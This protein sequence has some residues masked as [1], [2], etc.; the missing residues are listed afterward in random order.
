MQ[1]QQCSLDSLTP[2]AN[3]PRQ[4]AGAVDKVAASIEAF[5][6]KQPIVV[7]K[8]N[9]II[10]GHTRYLAA[11]QLG[12]NTVPVLVADD[13]SPDEAK[14]YRLADNRTHEESTWDKDLLALELGDLSHLEFDLSLTGF[15]ADELA[16]LTALA[17]SVAQGLTDVDDCH[18]LPEA[19]IAKA[20]DLWQLG[21]HVVCCGDS[22][23]LEHVKSLMQDVFADLVFTD[24]PY[25]VDY[26]GRTEDK[27]TMVGDNRS[28]PEFCQFLQQTF[29][30]C[31]KVVKK[32]ASLY[33]CHG[34]NYQ[35]EFQNALEANGFCIRNQ[36]IWAKHHFAWGMGRYKF[37]HEPI[38][39]CHQQDEIDKWYGDKSQATLWAF[40]KP[41][42]NPL[43]PTMK[44]VALIE[45]ALQNSSQPGD[46]ILDLFGG[47]GSTLI[48]CEKIGRNARLM[49]I[50][51]K[52]VDVI[53]Q[54][55]QEFTGKTA[56]L[57]K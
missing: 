2:Y 12:L 30:V 55:W 50:D 29:A 1:I 8:E 42:A 23:H 43:H 38:F 15:N 47:S 49:E 48:A 34:A 35:R 31:A 6:F 40:N 5:G 39:Y 33:V 22:T 57:M 32:T 11:K 4:N 24:P 21:R 3:N 54:R 19:S 14:A 10:V 9:V 25:N 27:L 36:I 37:Q 45:K 18:E 7:D 53:V 56:I 28:L 17:D 41:S 26:E 16:G 13:L 46:V 44:P 52:Y 51:P 20:G